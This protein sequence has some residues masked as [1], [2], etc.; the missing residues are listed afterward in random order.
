MIFLFLIIFI[1]FYPLLDVISEDSLVGLRCVDGD[2]FDQATDLLLGDFLKKV[3][4]NNSKELKVWEGWIDREG[5][6]SYTYMTLGNVVGSAVLRSIEASEGRKILLPE[7][8][9][10]VKIVP[11]LYYNRFLKKRLS[12]PLFDS[13]QLVLFKLMDTHEDRS[14]I[15]DSLGIISDIC[16][17]DTLTRIYGPIHKTSKGR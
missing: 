2:M 15:A 7:K 5:S 8:A 3:S 12:N 10:D 4:D 11:R 9:D 16:S 14:L 6:E 17:K 1:A 13:K